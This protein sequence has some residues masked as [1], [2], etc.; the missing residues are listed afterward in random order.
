MEQKKERVL[1]RCIRPFA[2]WIGGLEGADRVGFSLPAMEEAFRRR[3]KDSNGDT[4]ELLLAMAM[5]YRECSPLDKSRHVRWIEKTTSTE[6][7]A[8]D[9]KR[10]FPRARFIHVLRDPRDN[11]GSL[12][13]GWEKRYKQF[14]D[15]P[16][17][18][19]QSHV[20]RGKLGM[21]L[22]RWNLARYG[23]EDYLV[24][25]FEDLARD[26]AAVL[27]QVTAFLG[28][29]FDEA[30]LKPTVWGLPWGGNN[31]DGLTFS[32]VSAVNVDRWRDRITPEEAAVIEF[33]YADIMEHF[34]YRPV[35]SKA[36]Q[37]DAARNLYAWHNFAQVYSAR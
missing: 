12:K 37:V 35:T 10:W 17:R 18:L 1:E 19:L 3:T 13:S 8:A 4:R 21:E 31:F 2:E 32:G 33:Y 24:I 6:I 7:Y 27:R 28:V 14:N 5:T 30:I 26:P 23:P 25:R 22:A 15:S 11:Y 16:L 20:E 34:G 36:D 29:A 9:V